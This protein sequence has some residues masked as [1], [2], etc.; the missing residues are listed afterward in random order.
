[1]YKRNADQRDGTPCELCDIQRP[2]PSGECS[3][4]KPRRVQMLSGNRPTNATRSRTSGPKAVSSERR[5][6]SRLRDLCDEVLASYRAASD[7]D[8]ITESDRADARAMLARIAPLA[9]K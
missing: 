2:R 1:M 6:R 7:R 5:N 4:Q 9:A 3:Y 8:V